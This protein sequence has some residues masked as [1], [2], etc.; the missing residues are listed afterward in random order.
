MSDPER[1]KKKAVIHAYKS[2]IYAM[3]RTET[4]QISQG[5]S[6]LYT[7]GEQNSGILP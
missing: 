5:M 4:Q 1:R 7:T 2:E 3:S 6:N